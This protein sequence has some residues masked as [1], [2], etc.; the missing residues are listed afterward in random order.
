MLPISNTPGSVAVWA[1]ES[2]LCQFTD[3]PT[4]TITG[5]GENTPFLI[6]TVSRLGGFTHAG[7]VGVGEQEFVGEVELPAEPHPIA[8]SASKMTGPTV[9]RVALESL[10]TMFQ[11]GATPVPSRQLDLYGN[12]DE[13]ITDKTVFV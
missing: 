1:I 3:W 8:K 7:F 13:P 5:L 11:G 10:K 6:V 2:E 12:R 4:L 9:D